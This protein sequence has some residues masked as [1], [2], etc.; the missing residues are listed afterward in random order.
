MDRNRREFLAAVH[1]G[2]VCAGAVTLLGRSAA[3]QAAVPRAPL[4]LPLSSLRSSYDLVVIGSGYGGAVAAARLSGARSVCVLERGRE[5][6]PEQFPDQVGEVLAQMRSGANPLGLFD[7]R[8][9]ADLDVLVGNGLGGTSLINANVVIAADRDVFARAGWPQ[10]IRAAAQSGELATHETRV[11]QMLGVQRVGDAHE[12]RKHW[13]HRSTTQRRRRAGAAVEFR[14]LDLA[15][16]LDGATQPNAHGVWQAPCTHC[17]DCVSGCRVGAK[18]TLDVNYLALAR[19]RGSELYARVE[20]EHLTRA[21]SGR[22]RVHYLARPPVGVPY[23]G[24][25][26]ARS[27]VLAAGA[28]GSSE[29]LLRSRAQGLR[30]ADALGTRFSANGDVLGF[31]YNTDVQSNAQGY[32]ESPPPAGMRRCGPTITGAAAYASATPTQR[33]L[34]EE[35]ALPSALVDA[36]RLAMP[37]AAGLPNGTQELLRVNHDLAERGT[38][39]ALNHSMV[40]LG[41]GHDSNGGRLRLDALQRLELVWPGVSGEA[42]V[43]RI[44]QE[45]DRHARS[46]AGE[47][48][49][50]PR[51]H[52]L[53]GAA[54]TTVHPLG[55]CPMADS[56]ASGVV[57]AD[58]RVYDPGA[59]SSAVH[60][61]LYVM[62]GSTVPTS[63]GVNP[64]LTIAALAER[65]AAR[66]VG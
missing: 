26:E 41:I 22:W 2:V 48:V 18:S 39:G 51:T 52:P 42:F 17:G 30:L 12:L 1:A 7:Y 16:R 25:I 15:V 62:D 54:M 65:A 21:S 58:G 47:Y 43:S 3:A 24:T 11:R 56:S 40:Y 13:L 23:R 32:G 19:Q 29:I 66:F 36:L 50:S 4:T 20:V 57:D 45:M 10:A 6:L 61:G 9:G 63:V 8:A 55:G 31:A 28:L 34:I 37:V 44:R 33:F 14:S 49:D 64:L 53:F 60:A 5:W 59:G 46:F 27:V 35:G 38:T